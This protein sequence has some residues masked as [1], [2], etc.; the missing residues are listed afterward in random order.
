MKICKG[1]NSRYYSSSWVCPKCNYVPM[2][3]SGHYQ[4]DSIHG[5]S[6]GFQQ[7]TFAKLFEIEASN[8]WFRSR[9]H[10]IIWALKQYFEEAKKMLEIGCGTGFVLSGINKAFPKLSLTGSDIFSAGLVFA[11]KRMNDV[12]IIQFDASSI[13]F[14]HEF[15]IIGAFDVLEHIE[16]DNKVIKQMYQATAK[17]GGI[18]ITVPQHQFLW[19][20]ADEQACHKRR[21]SAKEL[22]NIVSSAGFYVCRCTSFVSLLFPA[23]FLSRLLKKNH[24]EGDEIF[25]E[26]RL[27][28]YLNYAF[29]KILSFERL[30]ISFGVNIPFGGSLLLIARKVD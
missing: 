7:E 9:N 4:L 25:D 23:M 16:D 1:C 30:M 21:Y 8:F 3:Q 29:E 28:G 2:F 17:G 12:E 26:L 14:E 5:K 15:D 18:I 10:L 13:P 20:Q 19:S 11:A 27:P 6:N 22:K 24:G